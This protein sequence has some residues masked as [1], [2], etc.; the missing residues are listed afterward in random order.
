MI[1]SV[2]STPN[3]E[4]D[5]QWTLEVAI[6]T[7]RAQMIVRMLAKEEHRKA[8]CGKTAC[9]VWWGEAVRYTDIIQCVAQSST[10]I[11]ID[12]TLQSLNSPTHRC[13][14]HSKMLTH[15]LPTLIASFALQSVFHEGAKE[16][17]AQEKLSISFQRLSHIVV[18]LAQDFIHYLTSDNPLGKL[19]NKIL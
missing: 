15:L 7:S 18:L 12:T 8:V 10:L 2:L 13:V 9:P 1:A 3:L 5:Y 16:L 11:T 14:I 6:S 19:R 17:T 4:R